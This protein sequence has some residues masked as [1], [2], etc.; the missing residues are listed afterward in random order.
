MSLS[1]LFCVQRKRQKIMAAISHA[2]QMARRYEDRH[3]DQACA[4]LDEAEA[5]R[6][7]LRALANH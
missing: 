3:A 1:D 5:G 2:E 4:W 7:A 6:T